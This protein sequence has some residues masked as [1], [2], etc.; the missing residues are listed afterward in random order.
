MGAELLTVQQHGGAG[1]DALKL[2]PDLLGVG[3]KGGLGEGGLVGAAAALVVVAAVLPVDMVPCMGQFH[4]RSLAV[5]TG[6]LPVFHQLGNSAH[7]CSPHRLV[8]VV[9][10]FIFLQVL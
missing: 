6:K 9:G 3:V 5:R 8:G 10:L 4:R 2:Q 7:R 1:V